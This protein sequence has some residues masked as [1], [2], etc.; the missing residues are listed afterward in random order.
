MGLQE[1]LLFSGKQLHLFRV[2]DFLLFG[3]DPGMYKS[4]A[5]V[6]YNELCQRLAHQSKMLKN[7]PSSRPI[8]QLLTMQ[9]DSFR[10]LRE[11]KHCFEISK[12]EEDGG[13]S[14]L[15]LFLSCL[16]QIQPR[17]AT[18]LET[19]ME[20]VAENRRVL[21]TSCFSTPPLTKQAVDQLLQ[22]VKEQAQ[23]ATYVCERALSS[24]P[25]VTIHGDVNA[26]GTFVSSHVHYV[27][28]EVLKNAMQATLR[29]GNEALPIEVR[30]TEGRTEIAIVICDQGGGMSR[31]HMRECLQYLFTSSEV[32]NR[33]QMQ[34][35][36]QP[37]SDPLTGI[38]TGIPV[39]RLYAQHFGGDLVHT[40]QEGY[41]TQVTFYISK[42]DP[43]ECIY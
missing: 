29:T 6:I 32:F 8:Q 19:L 11:I 22:V 42:L 34:Q 20:A 12:M 7:M 35:S 18:L 41:G 31:Q 25:Q 4:I 16:K 17:Q 38:G 23:H 14:T 37:P 1:L 15:K 5:P 2:S 24:A 39:S 10:Q 3:K 13:N 9:I 30:I 21:N 26:R 27:L 43:L 33:L 36:Y 40:S 28:F